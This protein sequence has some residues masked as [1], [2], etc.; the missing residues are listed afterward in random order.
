MSMYPESQV[1]IDPGVGGTGVAEFQGGR[2]VRAV[3][4]RS[5]E[6][7]WIQKFNQITRELRRFYYQTKGTTA[8]VVIESP[9]FFGGKNRVVAESGDL[10]KLAMMTGGILKE[11]LSWCSNITLATPG[12]WKGQLPKSVCASRI[13]K[14]MGRNY[15]TYRLSNHA[16]DA[17][18]I[19][20]WYFGRF[21]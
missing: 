4:L 5:N 2:L 18:G 1:F 11:S 13:K 15:P 3:T 7:L 9:V 10:C 14:I 17:I 12:E 20:L 8:F 21:K 16:I 19:G 6:N